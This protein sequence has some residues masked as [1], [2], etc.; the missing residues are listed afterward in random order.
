MAIP[1]PQRCSN[2]EKKTERLTGFPTT[3]DVLVLLA[4]AALAV[5]ERTQLTL[6]KAQALV[7]PNDRADDKGVIG[8]G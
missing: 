1:I 3:H 2:L 8:N 7:Q 5:C 6:Q 4:R